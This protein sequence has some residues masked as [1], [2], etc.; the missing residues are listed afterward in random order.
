MK[1]VFSWFGGRPWA[2][3]QLR[4][5]GLCPGGRT[6]TRR[7]SILR[8]KHANE[9]WWTD[10]FLAIATVIFL[11][12]ATAR[13]EPVKLGVDVLQE[14]G[15]A[16]LDGKKVGLVANPASVD[17]ALH[18]TV[19]VLRTSNRC[20]LVALF[21]PEH[22]VYGDEYA[23]VKVADRT[24]PQ[25][26][27]KI[28]SLYGNTRK[29]TP[30]ML[31]GLDALVFDLQD[32]GSRSYTYISSMRKCLEACAEAGIEFV[33]L[34]RPNP[35][36]GQRIEGPSN[37]EK[38]FE[39][40]ISQIDVPYLHGMTMGELAQLVRDRHASSYTKLRVVKMTGWKRG[41]T[42]AETGLCWMPTSPHIPKAESCAAYAAT[43]ILGEIA[44]LSNGVGYTLPFELVGAPDV[45]SEA[46][47]E[48]LNNFWGSAGKYYKAAAAG[49]RL[50]M[51]RSPCPKGLRFLPVR[52]KPFYAS[53]KDTLCGGVRLVIDPR[54]AGTLVEVN[55][56]LLDTLGGSSLVHK[57]SGSEASMFDKACGSDAPR[58]ALASGADFEP[59]FAAWRTA[60]VSFAEARKPFLL[61]GE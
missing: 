33:V 23:G 43:G 50:A 52:F 46:L 34:D 27:L 11:G 56:R 47:T 10:R 35:L 16:A 59:I 58:K 2:D 7:P 54:V 29:P 55:F 17:G 4:H 53:F 30:E 40:F 44:P 57:A 22:G 21:G 49:E 61:Y 13:A 26:G 45:K 60:C 48:A 18:P 14:E 25:T 51:L 9:P 19:E 15:F 8:A 32:I 28:H 3:H 6:A 36:G 20:K 1:R 39:S 12:L 31:R 5:R 38:G 24:D 41:M 37:V 42:W